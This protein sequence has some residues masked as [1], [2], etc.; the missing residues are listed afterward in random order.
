M[1]DT[2]KLTNCD[3]IVYV[4]PIFE[5]D[6]NEDIPRTKKQLLQLMRKEK[7]VYFHKFI[8][9]HCQKFPGVEQ[10]K[11]TDPGDLVKVSFRTNYKLYL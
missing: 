4:L 1:I 6:A 8:C 3:R 7:A 5:V 11:S 9:S 2:Y 10:W